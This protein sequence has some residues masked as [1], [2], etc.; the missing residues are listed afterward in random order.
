MF[1]LANTLAL[2]LGTHLMAQI[3]MKTTRREIRGNRRVSTRDTPQ[4]SKV[5][6]EFDADSQK[7]GPTKHRARYSGGH[8]F[9]MQ[10]VSDPV[11]SPTQ[12]FIVLSVSVRV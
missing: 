1:R 10:F 4:S 8:H 7:K 5:S 11:Q 9:I 2:R 12:V 6:L 3:V